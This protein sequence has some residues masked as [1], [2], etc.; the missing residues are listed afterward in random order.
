MLERLLGV[1][2][3]VLCVYKLELMN[4]GY[5]CKTLMKAVMQQLL[6]N[7][8]IPADVQACRTGRHRFFSTNSDCSAGQFD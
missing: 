3:S 7:C 4:T 8:S 2:H 1:T 5:I 6:L